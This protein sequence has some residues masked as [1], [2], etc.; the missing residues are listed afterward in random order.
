MYIEVSDLLKIVEEK[1]LKIPQFSKE[2][3]LI[4]DLLY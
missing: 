1:G 4:E 2:K 3:Y